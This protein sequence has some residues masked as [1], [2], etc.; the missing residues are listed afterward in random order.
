MIPDRHFPH[1]KECK[2]YPFEGINYTAEEIN[3]LLAAIDNK[4]SRGEIKDGCSA[5]QIAVKNGYKGTEEEWL[6]SLRGPRGEALKFADLTNQEVEEIRGPKGNDGLSGSTDNLIVVNDLNGEGNTPQKAYVLGASVGPELQRKIDRQKTEVDAARDEALDNIADKENN[7]LEAIGDKEESA[8]SNFSNQRV[9]PEMLSESTKQFIEA[10]GEGSVTNLA[11]DEDIE[12]RETDTG[13]EVLKFADRKY[14]PQ[15]FSGKGYKI[16]RKNIRRVVDYDKITEYAEIDT[17]VCQE[18]TEEVGQL[19]GDPDGIALCASLNRIYGYKTVDDV[20]KYYTSWTGEKF[21]LADYIQD[22]NPVEQVYKLKGE[23][24][25]YIFADNTFKVYNE[26]NGAPVKSVNVLTQDMINEENT[27][28]EIRYDFDCNGE[29]ISIPKNCI[30]KF[31]GGILRHGTIIGNNTKILANNCIQ[32]FGYNRNKNY[33]SGT[34]SINKWQCAWFGTIPDGKAFRARYNSNGE[35]E[36][37]T[38]S[39]SFEV[40]IEGTDNFESIQEALD[41][42]YNTNIKKVELGIGTYRIMKPLNIGWGG[43]Q[44]IYFKGIKNGHFGDITE[45]NNQSTIILC[46]TGTYGICINSGYRVRLSDFDLLGWNGLNYRKQFTM[47]QNTTYYVEN[48]EDWSCERVNKLPD[49]GLSPMSPYAGIITDAFIKYNE[50]ANPYELPVPPANIQKL[51]AQNSTG[52]TVERVTSSG[53]CVGFGLSV[54]AYEDN[55]DFY[56]FYNCKFYN[57]TY[58]FCTGSNQARNTA[59]HECDLGKCYT[60]ISNTKI[61][62]QNG[63]L[64]GYISNCW[65]DAC[66]KILEWKGDISPITFYNCYCE[67]SYMIGGNT[68]IT[69]IYPNNIKFI[70]CNFRL[71]S[72]LSNPLGIPT[73]YF[74]G[75]AFFYRSNISLSNDGILIPLF[76]GLGGIV[77]CS[78]MGNSSNISFVRSKECLF[79]PYLGRFLKVSQVQYESTSQNRINAYTNTIGTSASSIIQLSNN[80]V[81]K[82]LSHVSYTYDETTRILTLSTNWIGNTI[83]HEKT[84]FPGDIIFQKYTD[85]IYVILKI[86]PSVDNNTATLLCTPIQGF[87]KSN[88]KYVCNGEINENKWTIF[89]TRYKAFN[90]PLIVRSISGK[91][92]ILKAWDDELKAGIVLSKKHDYEHSLQYESG[93]IES[94]DK[95]QKKITLKYSN[96]IDDTFKVINGYMLS[97]EDSNFWNGTW[98]QEFINSANHNM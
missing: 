93:I 91:D 63:G 41:A 58:G 53:F 10:S 15:S 78:I 70:D 98:V 45:G 37:T 34:W 26:A 50:A 4:V 51:N 31:E 29:E 49:K 21:P 77:D 61:G 54:G 85:T 5:Y 22:G 17:V 6:A 16:L 81:P 13:I 35:L 57:N 79:N 43:Y 44:S 40:L 28:Y 89:S 3:R 23:Y 2:V 90:T 12:S 42:A 47:W 46:D 14:N 64:Y 7:A 59:L 38:E 73:C 83:S 24:T 95:S 48:P 60:A 1:D 65:F 75:S 32:I 71:I 88:N 11:D 82:E 74:I 96:N 27:V 18:V 80:S 9:T 33:I 20:T 87:R 30:L 76:I 92:I 68:S 36:K 25:Y 72:S 39:G 19:A 69:S 56:K 86:T 52:L 97:E 62:K 8:I 84:I 94:V 66:Y 55:G 67:N